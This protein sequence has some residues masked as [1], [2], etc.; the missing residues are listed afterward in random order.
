MSAIA[1]SLQ[2]GNI[3]TS[4]LD[5]T[6]AQDLIAIR[7][8]YIVVIFDVGQDGKV[9]CKSRNVRRGNDISEGDMSRSV[10]KQL[11]ST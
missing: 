8:L 7:R 1:P 4:D 10:R 11:T 6:L 3:R 9:E 2:D 5:E